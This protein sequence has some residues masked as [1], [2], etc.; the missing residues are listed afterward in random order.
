MG[1][2]SDPFSSIISAGVDIFSAR[3]GAENV[4]NTNAQNL[5]I[6]SEANA[7]SA[8][9]ARE[10]MAFQERMSNSAHQREVSDLRAAGLNPL[11]SLNSGASTPGGA[12][13]AVSVPKMDAPPS[14]WAGIGNA[15]RQTV[16]SANEAKLIKETINNAKETGYNTREDTERTFEARRGL[17]LENDLVE[18]RNNFFANNPALFKLHVMSGGLNS[19]SSVLRLLK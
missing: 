11:L 3:Q 1:F 18:K 19:A 15:I 5:R 13:G 14:K 2:F 8:N 17:R 16:A 12:M 6:A 10:Q 9:M 7:S 4:S